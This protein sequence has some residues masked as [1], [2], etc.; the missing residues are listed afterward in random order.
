MLNSR[1]V[2]GSKYDPKNGFYGSYSG[3]KY[4][5]LTPNFWVVLGLKYPK[6]DPVKTPDFRGLHWVVLKYALP[7]VLRVKVRP[8]GSYLGKSTTRTGRTTG[9]ST[10]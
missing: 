9:K 5:H 10:T 3:K 2:L 7:V 1:V 6:Y 8:Y 4:D